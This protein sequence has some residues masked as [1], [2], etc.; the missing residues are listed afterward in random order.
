[1]RRIV[2]SVLLAF[3][4]G[5]ARGQSVEVPAGLTPV[6]MRD[7]LSLVRRNYV[8]LSP[9]FDRAARARAN[10]LLDQ[11][12]AN[13]ERLDGPHYLLGLAKVAAAA[14]NGHD[15]LDISKSSLR[16]QVRLP[17][18]MVW[19]GDRLLVAR[20]A[21]SAADLA[22][23]EVRRLGSL[24]PAQIADRLARLQG[25]LRRFAR[26]NMSWVLHNPAMLRA[27]DVSPV[28]D[29]IAIV[30]TCPDGLTH[31]RTLRSLVTAKV[32]LIPSPAAWWSSSL[33]GTERTL[34]WQTISGP[35]PLYLQQ[36]E[37]L[38]RMADLPAMAALYVQ[39]R[40]N[41]GNAED[42]IDAFVAAVAA[43]LAKAPPLNLILDLRFDTGGDNTRN[44]TLMRIIAARV[45][46]R[47]F[48]ITGPYTFSAGIASLAA[49]VHD[50]GGKVTIVGEPVGDR[51]HWW[52]E[53]EEFCLPFSKACLNRQVGQWDVVKGC[54]G[55]RHCFGDQFDLR[56]RNLQPGLPASQ[57][58]GAWLAGRD[59]AMEAI[60]AAL[61]HR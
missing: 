28:A 37:R 46:G 5:T 38:F 57:T 27:L 33:T 40:D 53:R 21:P 52:S 4:A 23:C 14:D 42:S 24:T 18:R 13:A 58:V 49:L 7:E 6:Q 54:A 16:P 51:T 2:I 25:G 11:L 59:H 35:T 44:R 34:G 29:G 1:M 48:V 20:A 61:R 10:R 39:F 19:L 56:V 8:A 45:A 47:I 43:Q 41:S 31:R 55:Q 60:E 3:S 12:N 15:S 36:P 50:G 26:W 9:S 30:A 32:P 22:G 17:L